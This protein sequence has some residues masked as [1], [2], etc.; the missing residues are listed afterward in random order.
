MSRI[1]EPSRT[2]WRWGLLAG[3][4]AGV[5]QSHAVQPIA[6]LTGALEWQG[7]TWV[8]VAGAV[9]YSVALALLL[10][11]KRAGLWFAVVGPPVGLT[12]VL[13]GALAVRLGWLAGPVRV[14]AFQ[15]VGGVPQLA[16]LWL[17][18]AMLR[19]E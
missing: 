17:A 4:M 13:L 16:A 18:A 1:P 9:V 5:V 19:R 11:R 3:L 15:L 2:Y 8:S 12:L 10:L 14:D 6:A 7:K